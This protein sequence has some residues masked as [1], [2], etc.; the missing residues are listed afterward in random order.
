MP[1]LMQRA[2]ALYDFGSS[3][4][5][6][7]SSLLYSPEAIAEENDKLKYFC[8]T[9]TKVKRDTGRGVLTMKRMRKF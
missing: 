4:E 7:L 6:S 5:F 2:Y 8:P 3:T 9:V 1:N